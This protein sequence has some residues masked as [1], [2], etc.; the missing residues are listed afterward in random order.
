MRNPP[1]FRRAE[2]LIDLVRLAEL[3]KI[4][5]SLERRTGVRFGINTS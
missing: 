1:R 4:R 5:R 2:T 3:A